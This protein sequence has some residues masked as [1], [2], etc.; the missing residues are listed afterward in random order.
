MTSAPLSSGLH[1]SYVLPPSPL[2][3]YRQH[4]RCNHHACSPTYTLNLPTHV[5]TKNTCRRILHEVPCTCWASRAREPLQ[6]APRTTSP[7][8]RP[9]A[10]CEFRG[11][12]IDSPVGLL[13]AATPIC[14]NSLGVPCYEGRVGIFGVLKGLIVQ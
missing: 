11:L 8:F 3:H 14:G 4:A 2:F 12:S 1:I 7:L 6:Q 5:V 13:Y 10:K 9:I